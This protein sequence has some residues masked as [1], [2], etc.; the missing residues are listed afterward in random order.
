[1]INLT[2][3]EELHTGIRLFLEDLV[4]EEA[5]WSRSRSYI[6]GSLESL[7]ELAPSSEGAATPR[8]VRD[9]MNAVAS[10]SSVARLGNL[11]DADWNSL[12][13]YLNNHL[14]SQPRGLR[15]SPGPDIPQLAVL[16]ADWV[17]GQFALQEFADRLAAL[18]GDMQQCREAWTES[19][20][21]AGPETFWIERELID[22]FQCVT[23]ENAHTWL[24]RQ[25]SGLDQLYSISNEKRFRLARYLV[26]EKRDELDPP[27][28]KS[29]PYVPHSEGATVEVP[30]ALVRIAR[31]ASA[32]L[33]ADPTSTYA[34]IRDRAHEIWERQ[35]RPEGKALEHW[36]QAQAEEERLKR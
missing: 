36:V 32:N 26:S 20:I 27:Q 9:W 7:R 25:T 12:L 4:H 18:F 33:S 15:P 10:A 35:G 1:M 2:Y 8:R 28:R 3:M 14:Y 16:I 22:Q 17:V 29:V 24:R 5:D 30:I 19:G 11:S 34:R 6:G 21:R 31:W 13:S 23:P